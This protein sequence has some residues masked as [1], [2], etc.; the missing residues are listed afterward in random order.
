MKLYVPLLICAGVT[1]PEPFNAPIVTDDEWLV[2]T[3]PG[4]TLTTDEPVIVP[5]PSVPN[6]PELMLI[7]PEKLIVPR[8]VVQPPASPPA[9]LFTLI[10]PEP[11]IALPAMGERLAKPV[12]VRLMFSV[13]LLPTATADAKA[14]VSCTERVPPE[15]VVAPG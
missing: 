6:V 5:V 2:R 4:A 1:S 13:P 15:M 11:V 12:T 10:T 8:M 3:A 9:A 14:V 7:V